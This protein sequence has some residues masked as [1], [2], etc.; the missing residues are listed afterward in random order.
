MPEMCNRTKALA[1][2]AAGWK[3]SGAVEKSK[4]R[5]IGKSR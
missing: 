5:D 4:G 3:G 2:H 1:N